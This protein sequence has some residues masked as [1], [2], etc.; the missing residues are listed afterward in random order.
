[1]ACWFGSWFVVVTD[2]ALLVGG[3]VPSVVLL[4]VS[5]FFSSSEIAIFSLSTE[6]AEKM[7][8]KGDRGSRVLGE[9]REE[10]HRLGDAERWA[11]VVA[12]P[13]R[14]AE[15]ALF[16]LVAPLDW[17]TG[18][19]SKAM[20]GD[21][22]WKRIRTRSSWTSRGLLSRWTRSMRS[23]RARGVWGPGPQAATMTF[24]MGPG[25]VR[26][27]PSFRGHSGML[28]CL[29][30]GRSTRLSCNVSSA[31]MSLGRVSSGRMTSSMYP[32][33]AAL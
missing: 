5:A 1:M 30:F 9:L 16:P 28:P 18:W 17:V 27:K 33:A 4:V 29:R 14:V 12:V 3:L 22:T 13:L 25:K 2:A 26:K 10:P 23:R 20:R 6:K 15:Y 11:R 31:S 19:V 24:C 32:R 7:A 21:H 8:G